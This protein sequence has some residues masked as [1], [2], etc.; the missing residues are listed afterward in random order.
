MDRNPRSVAV[1]VTNAYQ[2]NFERREQY[3]SQAEP[4]LITYA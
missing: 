4:G 1:A 3:A 2:Q